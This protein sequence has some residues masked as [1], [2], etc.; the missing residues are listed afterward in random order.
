MKHIQSCLLG[1]LEMLGLFMA[2]TWPLL[3]LAEFM[4]K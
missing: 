2:L 1:I 3:L 4:S